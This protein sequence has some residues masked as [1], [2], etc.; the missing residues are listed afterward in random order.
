[1]P[2]VAT[3]TGQTDD[4]VRSLGRLNQDRAYIARL[5]LGV[6]ITENWQ[7]SLSGKFRDGI[8]FTHYRTYVDTDAAG[9]SQAILYNGYT[10]GIN[11]VD[12][13]FGERTDSF[14]NFDLRLKY[15]GTIRDVPFS[16]QAVCYNIWDFATELNEYCMYYDGVTRS[17]FSGKRYPLSLCTPRGLMLTLSVGLNKQKE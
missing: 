9:H 10:R 13:N 1:M 14:F 12:G 8:P 6:N 17:D 3:N 2:L 4:G 11:V 5:Q 7:L 15:R 16:V